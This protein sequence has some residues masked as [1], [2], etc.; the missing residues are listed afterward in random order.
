MTIKC[1]AGYICVNGTGCV[2][3]TSAPS[4]AAVLCP[5]NSTCKNGK[6]YPLASECGSG[7]VCTDGYCLPSSC[8]PCPRGAQ[9]FAGPTCPGGFKC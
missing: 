4:C 6:C 3:D 2:R 9:C 1:S 5:V 7:S 8:R